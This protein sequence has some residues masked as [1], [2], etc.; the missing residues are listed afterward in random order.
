MNKTTKKRKRIQLTNENK[1][2]LPNVTELLQ[3]INQGVLENQK[4]LYKV[5][6]ERSCIAI[7]LHHTGL[8]EK[9]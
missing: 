1:F 6:S 7:N 8:F 2:L 3:R 9:N 4:G 5:D